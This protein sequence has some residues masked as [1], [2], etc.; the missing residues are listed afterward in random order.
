MT[1]AQKIIK[2]LALAFAAVLI[3]SIISLILNVIYGIVGIVN[4]EKEQRLPH[5]ELESTVFEDNDIATLN[6]N[7]T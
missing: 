3:I 6:I 2:Y 7:V 1:T 5:K 4:V